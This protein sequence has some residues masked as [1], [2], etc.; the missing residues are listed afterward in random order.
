MFTQQRNYLTTH[1]SECIPVIMRHMTV[2]TTSPVIEII[3]PSVRLSSNDMT[4][5]LL[6]TSYAIFVHDT[7]DNSRH[8]ATVSVRCDHQN[9]SELN[10]N[11]LSFLSD[12][13]PPNSEQDNRLRFYCLLVLPTIIITHRHTS[14][15]HHALHLLA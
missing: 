3:T 14:C 2:L 1:F 9:L 6:Q 12:N 4:D 13:S 11:L 10:H 15:L 8:Q 5:S 7:T